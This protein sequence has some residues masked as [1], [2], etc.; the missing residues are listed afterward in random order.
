MVRVWVGVG[1][2]AI[3][4]TL[5]RRLDGVNF[6]NDFWGS[7][8]KNICAEGGRTVTGNSYIAITLAK[9]GFFISVTQ[10]NLCGAE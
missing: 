6:R 10:V 8:P 4:A 1:I 2:L 9:L 3:F 5:E 7:L